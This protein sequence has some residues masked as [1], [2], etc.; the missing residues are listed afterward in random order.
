[1]TQSQ[2]SKLLDV[3]LAVALSKL[4]VVCVCL[5]VSAIKGSRCAIGCVENVFVL[6]YQ[7]AHI[8]RHTGDQRV[9]GS[10]QFLSISLHM[11][12]CELFKQIN[13]GVPHE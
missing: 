2:L 5:T 12:Q 13:V 1:M 3:A 4:W 11:N 7:T 9:M 8:Q 6:V 10:K